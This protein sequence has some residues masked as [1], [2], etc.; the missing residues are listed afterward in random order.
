MANNVLPLCDKDAGVI[1][2][3]EEMLPGRYVPELSAWL[4]EGHGC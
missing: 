1:C 2:V 3:D 4:A